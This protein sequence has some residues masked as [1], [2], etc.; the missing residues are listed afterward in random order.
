[1]SSSANIE[2]S[3]AFTNKV[4]SNIQPIKKIP[5]EIK[6]VFFK[7]FKFSQFT[8][9][10]K[11]N[12]ISFKSGTESHAMDQFCQ[13]FSALVLTLSAIQEGGATL[14]YPDPDTGAITVYEDSPSRVRQFL[15]LVGANIT[16]TLFCLYNLYFGYLGAWKLNQLLNTPIGARTVTVDT[17][18]A[19]VVYGEGLDSVALLD[20]TAIRLEPIRIYELLTNFHAT[21]AGLQRNFNDEVR[22][23]ISETQKTLSRDILDQGVIAI[24]EFKAKSKILG[25]DGGDDALFQQAAFINNGLSGAID[26]EGQRALTEA[27]RKLDDIQV[28]TNRRLQD[29]QTNIGR[30]TEDVVTEFKNELVD[31]TGL[32]ETSAAYIIKGII[33][34]IFVRA[35]ARRNRRE[36]ARLTGRNYPALRGGRRSRR[37][38]RRKKQKASRR[39][40]KKRNTTNRRKYHRRPKTRRR[41]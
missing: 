30:K 17:S 14:E 40:R 32:I 2:R 12:K 3:L 31:A 22:K 36:H 27:R 1:M 20:P 38:R 34:L 23:A 28:T 15:I 29:F 7:F 11:K 25:L 10:A 16:P 19:L 37:R 26:R 5:K 9:L 8:K 6:E 13:L 21:I 33:F 24:E 4:F 18:Q 39:K 41:K 35:A